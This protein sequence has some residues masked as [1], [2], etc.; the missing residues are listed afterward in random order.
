MFNIFKFLSP[1]L[2]SFLWLGSEHWS[3]SRD[4]GVDFFIKL[5]IPE[6]LA[7]IDRIKDCSNVFELISKYPKNIQGLLM[8]IYTG[9]S[10]FKCKYFQ[11]K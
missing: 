3:Q 2:L 1:Y 11:E 6:E 8:D 10:H 9:C 5:R 4:S 7:E